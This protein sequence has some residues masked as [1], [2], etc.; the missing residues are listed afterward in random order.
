MFKEDRKQFRTRFRNSLVWR[1]TSTCAWENTRAFLFF[2]SLPFNNH[3]R[4]NNIN[5]SEKSKIISQRK[6]SMLKCSRDNF[7]LRPKARHVTWIYHVMRIKKPYRVSVCSPRKLVRIRPFR[8]VLRSHSKHFFFFKYGLKWFVVCFC[9][10]TVK[11][12]WIYPGRTAFVVVYTR[13]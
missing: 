4:R 11:L 13:Y 7:I 6:R 1:H 9:F 10:Y 3:S 2:F 8:T 12:G 5:M